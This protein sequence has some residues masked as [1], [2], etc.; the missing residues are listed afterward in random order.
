VGLNQPKFLIAEHKT[1]ARFALLNFLLSAVLSVACTTAKH[2]E[3]RTTMTTSPTL[4]SSPAKNTSL[5][6]PALFE[7]NEAVRRVYAD[8]VELDTNRIIVGDLNGD[9]SQ[10]LAVVVRPAAGALAKLN[11]EYAN[12]IVEDPRKIRLPDPNKAVQQLPDPP[13]REVIHQNDTLLLILH[14]Y[15]GEGWHHSYARQT[16]LLKNSVGDNMQAE[17]WNEISKKA[18]RMSG[19]VGQAGDVINLK[20]DGQEGFLYW[21]NGKYVWHQ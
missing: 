18:G 10:D 16:F 11:S 13:A 17:C 6:T 3:N 20:L 12:W 7:V 5:A 9:G 4:T 21:T 19:S 15:G 2:N 14:G 1:P 8:S